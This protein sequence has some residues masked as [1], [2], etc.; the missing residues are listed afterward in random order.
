MPCPWPLHPWQWHW[1]PLHQCHHIVGHVISSHWQGCNCCCVG[2]HRR[3][4]KSV[5][6]NI[7]PVDSTSGYLVID[8]EADFS[9][10]DDKLSFKMT[11]AGTF[12]FGT[13]PPQFSTRCNQSRRQQWRHVPHPHQEHSW[14][15]IHNP[16]N[17]CTVLHQHSSYSHA[18]SWVGKQSS[19]KY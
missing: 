6:N 19:E 18:A 14:W 4:H 5:K 15:Q 12:G 3:N 8:I 11:I 2:Q 16:I 10:N 1:R 13:H 7:V 9:S 17:N